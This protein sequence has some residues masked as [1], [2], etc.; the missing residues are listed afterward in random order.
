[1]NFILLILSQR[2]LEV[3]SLKI[4]FFISLL[5]WASSIVL[6]SS[7]LIYFSASS[8]L[9]L[10]SFRVFFSSPITY[11]WSFLEFSISLLKF[12]LCSSILLLS[13][14]SIFITISLNSLSRILFILILFSSFSGVLFCSWIETYSSSSSSC[15]Q[16]CACFGVLGKSAMWFVLKEWP[17]LGA[18]LWGS[19][20]QSH[21]STRA[22]AQEMLLMWSMFPFLLWWGH[23]C[24][25]VLVGWAT[26]YLSPAVRPRW[27]VG[28]GRLSVG[29]PNDA[30]RL[31]RIPKWHP[32][33][34]ALVRQP[35]ITKMA[36]ISVSVPGECPNWFL[37]LK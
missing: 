20:V 37:P 17:Y 14:V 31:R 13:S 3:S 25:G 29:M 36:P 35:E 5:V 7:L 1:M 8:N 32:P 23:S 9:L 2:S 4:F 22:G 27:A 28:M 24:C 16:L 21:W 15:L 26:A 6:S 34:L 11:I 30:S 18:V 10:N 19:E 33:V 12:S